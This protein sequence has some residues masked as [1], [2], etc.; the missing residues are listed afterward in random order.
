[1]LLRIA[2]ARHLPADKDVHRQAGLQ[3]RPIFPR[4]VF[5]GEEHHL[6]KHPL[7]GRFVTKEGHVGEE[8]AERRSVCQ[9]LRHIFDPSTALSSDDVPAGVSEF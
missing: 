1:M 7:H 3:L 4:E 6:W 5:T 9:L 8:A 2:P